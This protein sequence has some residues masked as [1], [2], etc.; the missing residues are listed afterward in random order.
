MRIQRI[1]N[2]LCIFKHRAS[3]TANERKA[4]R[5]INQLM[6][7]LGLVASM[8]EFRTQK[9][10]T[11][12]LVSILAFFLIEALFFFTNP[13]PALIFGLVG[14]I[15]FW[16]HFTTL[17]KP[18]APLFKI[19]K[20]HNVVGKLLNPDAA[21]KIIFTAHY[22]TARS[23]PMWNPKTVSSFRFNFL[24]GFFMLFA[25]QVVAALKIFS[26]EFTALNIIF[27]IGGIYVLAQIIILLHAGLRGALV[28]GASDNASGV[29]VMMNLAAELKEKPH[30][31]VEFWFVAT[32]S[33]EVGALGMADFMKTY[34]EDLE[35]ENT[36]FINFDNI[37]SGNLHYYTGEGM[38]NLFRFS[39]DLIASAKKATQQKPFKSITPA[40]YTLAYTDAIVPASRGWQS[41]L[42][43]ATDDHGRIPNWHWPTDVLENID[44]TIPQLASDFTLELL[45]NLTTIL[46]QK[47]KVNEENMKQFQKDIA[48]STD[49]YGEM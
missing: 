29:A 35:S 24:A 45:R 43:L 39:K 10:M 12:E 21:F 49:G 31:D 41:I 9:R 23:G 4:A 5:H 19:S 13:I 11:W 36:Y 40:K 42:L 37:G 2:E 22:D 16:G 47:R 25:M 3:G 18:L 6:R 46:E 20:S 7:N 38:L 44:F 14:I 8:D 30:P 33:E 17:F 48:N 26:I 34:G 32:G 1:M 27:I 28:Q 15:L